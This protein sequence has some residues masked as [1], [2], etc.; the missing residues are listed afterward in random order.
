MK[1]GD[2]MQGSNLFSIH[3]FE[4]SLRIP[5]YIFHDLRNRLSNVGTLYR[6]PR[7]C[8][9]EDYDYRIRDCKFPGIHC[10]L[11]QHK[12]HVNTYSSHGHKNYLKLIVNPQ[13]IIDHFNGDDYNFINIFEPSVD[14][15]ILVD[16]YIREFC[17][18]IKLD[19]FY[20]RRKGCE[21]N[22][23]PGGIDSFKLKRL[24][25]CVNHRF[26]SKDEV[27]IYLNLARQGQ[28][29][30]RMEPYK[31]YDEVNHRTPHSRYAVKFIGKSLSICVYDKQHQLMDMGIG[32]ARYA[33]GLLR[34]EI[35]SERS[36]LNY[37]MKNKDVE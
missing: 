21:V 30:A 34:F 14:N 33:E 25:F 20:D 16:K 13:H 3:T 12:I 26:D 31:Y 28:F 29:P 19:A 8:K 17:H 4:L 15:A 22:L 35:Q 5:T 27:K 1:E 9:T 6:E 23:A 7:F 37:L 2:N 10:S 18:A 24:D 11:V 36:K 32:D